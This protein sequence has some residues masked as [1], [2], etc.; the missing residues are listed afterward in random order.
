[1]GEI[2]AQILYLLNRHL[3]GTPVGVVATEVGFKLGVEPR[4]GQRARR[5]VPEKR[6]CS[7]ERHT[8]I[9]ERSSGCRL[10]GAVAG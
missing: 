7:S 10:R 1:M 8:G 2:V 9:S 6:S 4:Y 3:Q 5:R